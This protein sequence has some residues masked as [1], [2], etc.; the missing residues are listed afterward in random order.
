MVEYNATLRYTM[1]S[2][3]TINGPNELK[4]YIQE[5]TTTMNAIKQRFYDDI[6]Q[7][8]LARFE[9]TP[10]CVSRFNARVQYRA[11]QHGGFIHKICDLVVEESNETRIKENLTQ[12]EKLRKMLV[13]NKQQRKTTHKQN[14]R[15]ALTIQSAIQNEVDLCEFELEPPQSP[16]PSSS[17][18]EVLALTVLRLKEMDVSS[19]QHHYPVARNI[20][21]DINRIYRELPK[22]MYAY[23]VA[24]ENAA[25]KIIHHAEKC[26]A[27]HEKMLRL[28]VIQY[29]ATLWVNANKGAKMDYTD[30]VVIADYHHDEDDFSYNY[31]ICE[32]DDDNIEIQIYS[33]ATLI[34]TIQYDHAIS[35][36]IITEEAIQAFE[37]EQQSL[38]FDDNYQK[39]Y[40][41]ESHATTN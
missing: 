14:R 3:K 41:M 12:L 33:N 40:E 16:A 39:N 37:W 22:A 21:T 2:T 5:W 19:K 31:D 6:Y 34:S 26:R 13:N 17:S 24:H 30:Y 20:L 27:Y 10:I 23:Q 29:C 11:L 4:K 38:W 7:G 36:E 15:I 32:T 9:P 8:A 35:S 18:N 1:N 28:A 25:G